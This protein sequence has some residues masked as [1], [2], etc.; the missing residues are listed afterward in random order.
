[1]KRQMQRFFEKITQY[2]QLVSD[3]KRAVAAAPDHALAHVNWGIDLAQSGRMEDALQKFEQAAALAP[4]RWEVF[5]NWG[6]ALARVNRLEEATEKFEQ[7]IS[8]SPK[9][10]SNY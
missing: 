1:M 10:P 9:V 6:V 8:L 4:Q 5:T 7:A 2:N 3:Y